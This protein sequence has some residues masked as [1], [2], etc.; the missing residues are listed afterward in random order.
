MVISLGRASRQKTSYRTNF[1][2]ALMNSPTS[3]TTTSILTMPRR[4]PHQRAHPI[5]GRAPGSAQ[6]WCTAAVC[7]A[8]LQILNMFAPYATLNLGS[9]AR[10]Q[11]VARFKADHRQTRCREC[12][13]HHLRDPGRF[14]NWRVRTTVRNAPWLLRWAITKTINAERFSR[15]QSRQSCLTNESAGKHEILLP[16]SPV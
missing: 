16:V 2:S 8:A 11:G 4:G 13:R 12:L 1:C 15:R 3:P 5:F 6:I 7:A 10:V 9:F 14:R